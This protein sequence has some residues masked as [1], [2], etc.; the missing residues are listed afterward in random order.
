MLTSNLTERREV[1]HEPG[2]WF[3]FKLLS[4][5]ALEDARQARQIGALRSLSGLS[6]V[7]RDL[8]QARTNGEVLATETDPLNDYD[9]ATLLKA[10]V[11]EWS[12]DAPVNAETLADLD[13]VTAEWASR[14]ILNM[15]VR[16]QV[17]REAGFFRTGGST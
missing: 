13:D 8:Q 6:D 4:W 2:S 16:R 15:H 5:K 14:E 9:R 10:S 17:E 7:V 12:Y 1:P 11:K 3:V